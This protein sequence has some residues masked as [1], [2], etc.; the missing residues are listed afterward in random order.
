LYDGK[1]C[2]VTNTAN[3]ALF[4]YAVLA[5]LYKHGTRGKSIKQETNRFELYNKGLIFC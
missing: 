5:T 1:K 4:D 3:K 2:G